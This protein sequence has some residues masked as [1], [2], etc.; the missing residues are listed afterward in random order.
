MSEDASRARRRSRRSESYDSD[1]GRRR[2]RGIHD[3][4]SRSRDRGGRTR[5]SKYS[6]SSDTDSAQKAVD[7]SHSR[8]ARDDRRSD[9]TRRHRNEYHRDPDNSKKYTSD[10]V[11]R[12]R[13]SRSSS[14]ESSINRRRERYRST[15]RKE[16]SRH[17]SR[18]SRRERYESERR[19]KNSDKTAKTDVYN[20][21]AERQ[22]TEAQ[23]AALRPGPAQHA[24]DTTAMLKK[25]LGD[26]TDV[27]VAI[28]NNEFK[29][30]NYAKAYGLDITGFVGMQP[31]ILNVN[32]PTEA[33]PVSRQ[34][35][36]QYRKE[37]IKNH[38]DRFWKCNKCA[39]MNYLSNYE[40]TG[41]HYL[42]DA[43][44]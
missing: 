12:R 44:R 2:H 5:T 24:A 3:R 25:A 40:C 14:D 15:E 41:C 32:M 30:L 29:E 37:E 10:R 18:S 6:P 22:N 39:Y 19:I 16:R 34:Q 20:A 1:R 9:E 26:R 36:R 7:W 42:R 33:K 21:I 28:L 23:E 35:R 11:S 43:N 17:R 38:P 8:H 27:N 13:K 31:D 4:S